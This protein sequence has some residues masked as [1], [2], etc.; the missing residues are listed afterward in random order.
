MSEEQYKKYLKHGM[1]LNI[2][3]HYYKEKGGV[4]PDYSSFVQLFSLIFAE[5][6]VKVDVLILPDVIEYYD[7]KFQT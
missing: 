2:Y 1:Y 3:Y 7:K 4:I 6:L 5:K